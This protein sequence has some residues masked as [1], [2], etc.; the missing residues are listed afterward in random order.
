[1]CLRKA[2]G[3]S[4]P[5][6]RVPDVV[7]ASVSTRVEDSMNFTNA[8]AKWV[9]ETSRGIENPNILLEKFSQ[10]RKIDDPIRSVL[11]AFYGIL[12]VIGAVGNALVVISFTRDKSTAAGQNR[13]S[14]ELNPDSS[15]VDPDNGL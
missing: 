1:M 12:V 13:R 8:S 2:K 4:F 10:N 15:D 5:G 14:S 11:L 6:T 7:T 9:I 3:M